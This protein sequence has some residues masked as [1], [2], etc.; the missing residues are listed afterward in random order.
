MPRQPLLHNNAN[1]PQPCPSTRLF[2]TT[3]R[4]C[5][6]LMRRH[7]RTGTRSMLCFR[8]TTARGMYG[9][10]QRSAACTALYFT[11]QVS[12]STT[13]LACACVQHLLQQNKMHTLAPRTSATRHKHATR[14]RN[15][16][17]TGTNS[18][19]QAARSRQ[20]PWGLLHG[21]KVGKAFRSPHSETRTAPT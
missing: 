3:A 7:R 16:V 10:A 9:I 11:S 20:P 6:Y 21:F 4:F 5:R 2:P 19:S 17:R 12:T 15:H 13:T 8:C 14:M 18:R 1:H